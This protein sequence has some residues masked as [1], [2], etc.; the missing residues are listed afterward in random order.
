MVSSAFS[1]QH[2]NQGRHDLFTIGT[3]FLECKKMIAVSCDDPGNDGLFV[4]QIDQ[5]NS[6]FG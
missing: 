1:T 3:R 6:I 5:T 4:R 2:Y